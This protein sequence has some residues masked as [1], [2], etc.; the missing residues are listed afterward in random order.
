MT[1]NNNVFS[2]I[3]LPYMTEIP[4]KNTVRKQDIIYKANAKHVTPVAL[5]FARLF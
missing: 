1:C 4:I 5:I 3:N 2:A